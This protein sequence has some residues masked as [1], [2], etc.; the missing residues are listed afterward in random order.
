MMSDQINLNEAVIHASILDIADW[1]I[2]T[3]IDQIKV[4]PSNGWSFKFSAQATWP[5]VLV[6]GDDGYLQYT[7]WA[8]VK[9]GDKWYGSGFIQFWRGRPSTGGFGEPTWHDDFPI[10][11]GYYAGDVLSK[12]HPNPG[13]QMAFMVSAGN[14]RRQSGVTSVRERS[15][16][17]VITLPSG[18]TGEFHFSETVPTPEPNPVPPNPNPTPAPNVDM[19]ALKAAVGRL[20]EGMLA[21]LAKLHEPLPPIQVEFPDYTGKMVPWANILLKAV[22]K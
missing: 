18:D 15:N 3:T 5:D 11:W 17:V 1:P 7:V 9:S 16:V 13:D 12:Y 20:E 21:I 2:T 4:S 14:A 10:N 6:F 8:F 22:K 19:E